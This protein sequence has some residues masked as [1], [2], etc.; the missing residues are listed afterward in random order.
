MSDHDAFIRLTNVSKHFGAVIAVDQ[1][2][3]DISQGEFFSLLGPSGCG[4]TTLL[5][6]LAGFESPTS[7][8][9]YIDGAAISQVPPH[10]RP[11]NMV[12]QSYAIFPH[13]DVRRNLSYGLRFDRIE[14]SELERRVNEALEMVKLPGFGD[15]RSNELSGGQRQRVP[16]GP[17]S[18]Q[19][20]K[21]PAPR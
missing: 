17:G 4:K 6:M 20:A 16:P 8:E 1:V 9:L 14:K 21:S 7:G 5:R 13:L 19:T 11:T 2:N 15:R 3:V 18:H 12:F 10:Q